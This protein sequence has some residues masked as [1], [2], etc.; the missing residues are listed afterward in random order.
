MAMSACTS[1]VW[2]SSNRLSVSVYNNSHHSR[3]PASA[4]C[5]RSCTS[6]VLR[7][8]EHSYPHRRVDS[9]GSFPCSCGVRRARRQR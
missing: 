9:I 2:I 5:S 4:G 1:S 3:T 6:T 8:Q 7:A